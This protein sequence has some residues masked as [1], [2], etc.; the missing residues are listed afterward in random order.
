MAVD[1]L[2]GVVKNARLI[3]D[4][5]IIHLRCPGAFL[6]LL[7]ATLSGWQIVDG[8]PDDQPEIAVCRDE[9]RFLI[10]SITLE[11]PSIATDVIDALNYIFLAMAYLY[12]ARSGRTVLLHGVAFRS[13]SEISVVFGR[14]GAG[15]SSLVFSKALEGHRVF[16][17]DLLIWD[18]GLNQFKALGLP[19]RMRRPIPEHLRALDLGQ[20]L[21]AGARIAYSR[22]A[23]FD[24]VSVGRQFFPDQFS[25][26]NTRGE[27]RAIPL[28]RLI[29]K[30]KKYAISARFTEI[31]GKRVDHHDDEVI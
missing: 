12:K 24:V 21:I 8:S 27:L 31:K 16:A 18:I 4:D 17:D 6:P 5:H 20:R 28:Y 9:K 22:Q 15:K 11:K 19:L 10:D 26:F 7:S 3:G 30:I 23:A 29:S 13:G 14:K 2:W 25:E 1:N